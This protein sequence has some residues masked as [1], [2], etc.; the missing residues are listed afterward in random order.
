MKVS[1]QAGWRISCLIAMLIGAPVFA[2]PAVQHIF[3]NGQP[4]QIVLRQYPLVHKGLKVSKAL[5]D[6]QDHRDRKALKVN[7][8]RDLHKSILI[9]IGIVLQRRC[10]QF[11]MTRHQVNL[12]Q[13]S[14]KCDHMIVLRRVNWSKPANVSIFKRGR[15]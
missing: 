2:A 6:R 15:L 10:L 9:C 7:R 8:G 12:R 3:S 13:N 4:E 11:W 5:L 14:K 1:I